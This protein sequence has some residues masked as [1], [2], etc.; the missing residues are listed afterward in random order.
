MAAAEAVAVSGAAVSLN[1]V[2]RGWAWYTPAVT[3]VIVVVLAMALLRT[4]R[5]RPILVAAGGFASLVLILT[6]TFFRRNSIAGFIP[7]GETIEALGLYVRRATETVLAESA[8][9]APNVGIVL[10][11]CAVLGLVVI[12]VDALAIPLAMPA[13][14]GLGLLAV[15]VVPAMI[16]PQSVG[17]WA[18]IITAIGYLMILG[19]S[20][21]FSAS[22]LQAGADRNPGQF[23]RAAMTGGVALLATLLLQ[24]LIPGFDRGTF[25]QGSRL[26]PW[27][28]SSGLN[29][30]ISL[31][32]SLR[33]PTGEGRIT[34]ASTSTSPPY[35]RLVT[36]ERFDGESWAQD[37]RDDT[38][39]PGAARLDPGYEINTTEIVRNITA[40]NAGQFTSP[41][42]PVPYAPS[43]V[44]GLDGRWSWDPATLSIKGIDTNSRGQQY[45]VVSAMPTLTANLLAQSSAPVRG[46]SEDFIRPPAGVPDIVRTTAD[47]VTKG[48]GT[49]YAKAIAI[50]RY[51]RSPEFSYSLESPV[52][53]GYDGNGLSVLADFLTQ[54][55]G[56]CIHYA[57]AM[58]VMARL[59][60]IPSRIAVG[61][62]PGR[63]TG[64]TV[65]VAGQGALPEY[66]VDARDAHAWPELYFQGLGWVPFEPTPSR[67]VVPSY[68]LETS[69]SGGASTNQ[70]NDDLI[71]SGPASAAPLPSTAPVPLPG[72]GVGG[73]AGFQLLPVLYGAMGALLLG[74]LVASPRLIRTG[75]R[76]RRLRPGWA[77][78]DDTAL[79]SWAELR[80]L[81][82][83]YGVPPRPSETPRHFSARL[84]RSGAL[85][86]ED[87]R[88]GAAHRAVNSLVQ[89]FERREYGRPLRPR[90]AP[91]PAP[92]AAPDESRT[93]ET[94][95]AIAAARIEVIIAAL[96]ANARRL[97]RLRA[98]WLP[99][100]VMSRWQS[101]H[102]TPFRAVSRGAAAWRR[103]AAR[104]W[105]R[106]REGLR[107]ARQG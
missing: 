52:Q 102:G 23:R 36:V 8:P 68:A 79:Q 82:I 24:P 72:G 9:V 51:L 95:A 65:S 7:S 1:G 61:Y 85:G 91:A 43:G 35:L 59:E 15:L 26:N 2:L 62:A 63:P 66:E 96:R 64:T 87:G 88:D 94:P 107:R 25:P 44:N 42:L 105:F 53:G 97:V 6:F 16:K 55:S 83:D 70:N 17:V 80:D 50:Q 47:S 74:L 81:A 89:D 84:R 56:Y 103:A 104:T 13:T 86:E 37:D 90:A 54:K 39:R 57:S 46:I 78:S 31:G 48:S 5:A 45:V 98:L 29:P 76:A 73:A 101:T 12:I 100:A 67:G 58:A 14:S 106:M 28:S 32:N 22:R 77:A 93:P 40:I 92:A 30:M 3:T 34:Y 33:S 11:T 27:G 10:V 38:R 41:Y 19:C 4:V 20:Q 71:P 21:W 60:G 49:S 99:P 69:T 75:L 18:F